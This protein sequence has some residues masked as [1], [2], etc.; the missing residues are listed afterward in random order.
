MVSMDTEVSHVIQLHS[1]WHTATSVFVVFTIPQCQ[2]R[3]HVFGL[4]IFPCVR[5]IIRPD[6]RPARNILFVGAYSGGLG[7]FP[8]WGPGANP[9][10][11][12]L[13]GKTPM[14]LKSNFKIEW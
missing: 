1:Y 11:R 14:M 2:Q 3:H 7:L 6:Q 4:S 5:S 13:G 12:R 9:P 10:V 8:Q